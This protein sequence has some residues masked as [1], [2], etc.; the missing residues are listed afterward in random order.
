MGPCIGQ[1]QDHRQLEP[2][3]ETHPYIV[4]TWRDTFG[5]VTRITSEDW[6]IEANGLHT[7]SGTQT[8]G[9]AKTHQEPIKMK[10]LVRN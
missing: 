7:S 9:A 2:N 6:S 3:Y 4:D 8:V 10:D 5:D 1:E